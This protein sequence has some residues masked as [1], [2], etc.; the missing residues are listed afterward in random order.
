[1]YPDPKKVKDNRWMLRLNDYHQEQLIEL[2]ELTG[3]QPSVILREL[4]VDG[5]Q[6][7]LAHVRSMQR[8][9]A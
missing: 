2:S 1:M 9:V 3:E 5:L 6:R 7:K 4:S 8:L